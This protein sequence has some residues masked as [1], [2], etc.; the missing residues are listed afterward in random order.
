[1]KPDFLCRIPGARNQDGKGIVTKQALGGKGH[2][3]VTDHSLP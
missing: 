1:M 3:K 2:D